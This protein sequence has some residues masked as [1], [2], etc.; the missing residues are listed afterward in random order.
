MAIGMW[1]HDEQLRSAFQAT[2][3]SARNFRPP[4]ITLRTSGSAADKGC[5]RAARTKTA[6]ARRIET[7]GGRQLSRAKKAEGG[8]SCRMDSIAKPYL[9]F[10]PT[11]GR[12]VGRPTSLLPGFEPCHLVLSG[13]VRARR[14]SR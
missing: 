5:A 2:A 12:E 9:A 3:S 1:W 4:L 10:Q 13:P 11:A 14:N 8:L 6:T 7:S